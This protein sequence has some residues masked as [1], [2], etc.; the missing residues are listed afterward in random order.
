MTTQQKTA[1]IRS[2]VANHDD[3]RASVKAAKVSVGLEAIVIEAMN[4]ALKDD[5][6]LIFALKPKAGA[7]D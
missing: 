6:T 1:A 4:T 5:L 2:I 7:S 3:N